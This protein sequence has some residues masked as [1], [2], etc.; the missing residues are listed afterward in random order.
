[1]T[2]LG[3]P[4][5]GTVRVR[6]DLA[7]LA[8]RLPRRP[9]TRFAPSPTGD[10]HLGHVVNALYVWGLA[11]AL[12]GRVLLR[13]ED[14]DRE[15]YRAEYES[16]IL[17]DLAWLGL[18]P[19]ATE[20]TGGRPLVRQR[21]C[22]AT[23]ESA[24]QRLRSQGLIYACGCSRREIGNAGAARGEL[25][26]PG[27]CRLRRLPGAGNGLR[28]QIAP[29]T[30]R[31][32]DG[33]RGEQVQEPAAQCGDVLVR[34]RAGQWTY[35]FAVTVDD[36]LQ[37]VDLVVRGADLLPSTGRQI[38]LA[39]LL[40]RPAPAVFLHHPLLLGPTGSKLS[41]ANRDP[42]ISELRRGGMSAR[43][44]LGLAA[45]RAGLAAPDAAIEPGE[46]RRDKRGA[47]MTRRPGGGGGAGPGRGRRLD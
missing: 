2:D 23:Y 47:L 40:R 32:H 27:T 3:A 38:R 15:R 18:E 35:Q 29:G 30:E 39:R 10:L 8:A 44:V 25:R 4:A 1:M 5:P 11:R 31:F 24:L 17:A 34:D 33:L 42:G 19:D 12:G 21:D 36:M 43:E 9:L 45:A 26:Y 7:A 46:G 14:H 37:G 22:E 20:A 13:I 28:A 16:A 6:P 41:K